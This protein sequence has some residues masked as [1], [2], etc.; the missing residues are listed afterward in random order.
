M[1]CQ[2]NKKNSFFLFDNG[3]WHI[4]EPMV[5]GKY[6]QTRQRWIRSK[7]VKSG[8]GRYNAVYRNKNN[9]KHHGI[10]NLKVRK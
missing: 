10:E 7:I 1:P 4:V 9:S 6:T 2:T 8:H 5:V 3:E